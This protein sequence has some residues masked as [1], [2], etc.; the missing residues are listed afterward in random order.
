MP[1]TPA[2]YRPSVFPPV[3]GT[4]VETPETHINN[5]SLAIVEFSDTSHEKVKC[6]PP[7]M[8]MPPMPP[9]RA[10]TIEGI[11]VTVRAIPVDRQ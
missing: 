4:F 8:H 2:D 6:V 9:L 10:Q 3:A 5:P 11:R 1:L 7:L